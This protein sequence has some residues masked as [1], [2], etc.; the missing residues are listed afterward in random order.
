M[1]QLNVYS[2]YNLFFDDFRCQES[3]YILCSCWIHTLP[4]AGSMSGMYPRDLYIRP[5]SASDPAKWQP[6]SAY[7][8]PRLRLGMLLKVFSSRVLV[9]DL[10]RLRRLISYMLSMVEESNHIN[11]CSL[12]SRVTVDIWP[13]P[14]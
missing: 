6:S 13:G 3:S 4:A 10:D 8:G 7:S 11:K 2:S 1:S 5:G 9:L 14:R 12:P